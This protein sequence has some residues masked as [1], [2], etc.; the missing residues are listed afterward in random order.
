L[1]DLLEETPHPI[2]VVDS[3]GRI[4]LASAG[5]E[6]VFGRPRKELVGTPL[7]RLLQRPA[8]TPLAP[9]G[10][11]RTSSATAA[12]RALDD[13]SHDLRNSLGAIGNAVHYLALVLPEDERYRRYLGL[14]RRELATTNRLVAGLLDVS[15]RPAEAP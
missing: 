6:R 15:A 13:A 11:P 1:A 10:T 14:I 4:V 9:S 7:E 5:T 3:R 12:A 2:V 8:K